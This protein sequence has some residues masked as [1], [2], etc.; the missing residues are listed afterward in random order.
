MLRSC[1][2]SGGCRSARASPSGGSS[3]TFWPRLFNTAWLL[4]GLLSFSGARSPLS[5]ASTWVTRRQSAHCSIATTA[6]TGA[7]AGR[8][9]RRRR[10]RLA[11]RVGHRKPVRCTRRRFPRGANVKPGGLLSR[12]AHDP[13]LSPRGH[14]PRDPGEPAFSGA[15]DGQR[16]GACATPSR[17]PLVGGG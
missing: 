14:H 11:V 8:E 3:P 16:R 15:C 1:V 4:S 2:I 10:E 9:L 12:V 6:Q 17:T 7:I 5:P 13:E